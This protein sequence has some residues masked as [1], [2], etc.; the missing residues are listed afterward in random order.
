MEQQPQSGSVLWKSGIYITCRVSWPLLPARYGSPTHSFKGESSSQTCFHL[1]F[2]T[3]EPHLG[4]KLLFSL[5]KQYWPPEISYVFC[6][7]WVT[8]MLHLSISTLRSMATSKERKPCLQDDKKI[9]STKKWLVTGQAVRIF[10]AVS[11]I[12]AQEKISNP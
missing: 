2:L 5:I 9:V 7:S 10:D 1:K 4:S 11:L 3:T 8:Y 6:W 12:Y